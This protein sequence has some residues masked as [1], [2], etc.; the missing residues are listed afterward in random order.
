MSIESAKAF[1]EK[2][3]ADAAFKS[4][5]LSLPS[6]GDERKKFVMGS[7]FDFT[8]AELQQATATV[9][10]EKDDE[11]SPE[12]LDQIAAVCIGMAAVTVSAAA[13]GAVVSTVVADSVS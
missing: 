5:V 2:M 9:T 7:G 12:D 10:L 1:L 8:F 3:K 4:K 11:I 6:T 13:A